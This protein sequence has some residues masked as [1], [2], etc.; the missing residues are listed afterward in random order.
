MILIMP[1]A[2]AGTHFVSVSS[3]PGLDYHL[4]VVYNSTRVEPNVIGCAG[5]ATATVR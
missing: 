3:G 2:G 1:R 5:G 4:I